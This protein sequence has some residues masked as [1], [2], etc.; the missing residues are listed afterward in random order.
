MNDKKIKVTLV[1]NDFTVGGAQK[2]IVDQLKLFDRRR[3]SYELITLFEFPTRRNFYDSVP[4]DVA[5]WR[6]NFSGFKDVSNWFKLYRLLNKINP[7][8]VVSHLFFSNTAV[9]VLKVCCGYA[10]LSV[11]HNTYVNKTKVQILIDRLLSYLTF[12]IIAVSKTVAE[13]TSVQEGIPLEKFVVICDGVNVNEIR[14]KFDSLPD[15][16]RLKQSLGFAENHKLI[17]NVARLTPQKN[18]LSLIRAFSQFVRRHTEYRLIIVG[19]GGVR[20]KLEQ[21][22]NDCGVPDKVLM[23]GYQ[24]PILYYKVSEFFVLT[25]EIEGFAIAGIEAMTCGLPVLSTKTAGPDQ[26]LREGEN[27]FFI[28]NSSVN[29]IVCGLERLSDTSLGRL[30]EPAVNTAKQFDVSVTERKYSQ[31]IIQAIEF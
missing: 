9:R 22:I 25:S 2:L 29:A 6:L 7:Q 11:E 12:K 28:E 31:L 8:V 19:E 13:F 27:G 24:D 21:C 3:F 1:I 10:C 16:D 17:V 26:Y 20:Q 18:H 4:A 23:P 5:V 15:K 14:N 30:K